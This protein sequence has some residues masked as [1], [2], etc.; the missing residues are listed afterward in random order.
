MFNDRFV[1]RLEHI[2]KTHNSL[3]KSL[4]ELF[5]PKT[6][7]NSRSITSRKDILKLVQKKLPSRSTS[8]VYV[9]SEF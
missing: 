2:C 8:G 6:E 5:I 3:P 9:W 1:L 7:F 4:H